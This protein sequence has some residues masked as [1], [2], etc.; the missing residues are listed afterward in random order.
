MKRLYNVETSCYQREKDGI[1]ILRR[2]ESKL[3]YREIARRCKISKSSVERICK[4]GLEE[5]VHK[6]RSGRPEILSRRDKDRFL[7]KF[8]TMRESNPN[9]HV[10][11]VAKECD[12]TEIEPD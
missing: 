11:E 10:M 2:Q 1:R 12:I 7:R 9:V 8:K 4:E 5:K 6:K 3:S